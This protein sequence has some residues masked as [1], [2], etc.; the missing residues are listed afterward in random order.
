[1]TFRHGNNFESIF[2]RVKNECNIKRPSVRISIPPEI[3][4]IVRTQLTW[5][6]RTVI[7]QKWF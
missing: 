5:S 4:H 2:L 7:I 6:V 3:A 1:M